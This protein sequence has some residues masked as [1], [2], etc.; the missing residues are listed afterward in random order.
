VIEYARLRGIRVIPEFDSPGKELLHKFAKRRSC[1][2][3]EV[4]MQVKLVNWWFL[5]WSTG[6][7][8]P[9]EV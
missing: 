4:R 5:G 2:Y 7:S 3:I 8:F 9:I 6:V 1:E